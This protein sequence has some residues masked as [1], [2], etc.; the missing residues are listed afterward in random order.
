MGMRH[1]SY[2]DRKKLEKLY[3]SG[4]EISE[5]AGALKVHE[6]TIYRELK[7][8]S[9]ELLDCNGRIGY[10]AEQGQL[11]LQSRLTRRKLKLKERS[12]L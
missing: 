1:L 9:T 3:R 6:A 4:K 12:D 7:R 11:T 10:S 8:G 5:I 2:D